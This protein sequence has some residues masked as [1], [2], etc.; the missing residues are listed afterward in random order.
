MKKALIATAVVI[1][2]AGAT[3]ALRPD[4]FDSSYPSPHTKALWQ[5]VRKAATDKMLDP[6]S[7][8]FSCVSFV[9]DTFPDGRGTRHMFRGQV[10][11]KNRFGGYT[12]KSAFSWAGE[13]KDLALDQKRDVLILEGHTIPITCPE[14]E[15]FK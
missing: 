12:G 13:D 3:F 5:E 1:L 15:H 9:T 2:I 6:G 4:L 7:A 11:A 14:V 8:I 10:N